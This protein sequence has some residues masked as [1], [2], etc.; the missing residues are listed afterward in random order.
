ME[1]I[2]N[3]KSKLTKFEKYN[4]IDFTQK[5]LLNGNIQQLTEYGKIL[6]L[7]NDEHNENENKFT[8]EQEDEEDE[9]D[10]EP[11][12]FIEKPNCLTENELYCDEE[13]DI[14]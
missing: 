10:E 1:I 8:N 11:E 13:M 6:S 9:E 3:I 7:N 14:Y 12:E 2:E 4:F 5:N